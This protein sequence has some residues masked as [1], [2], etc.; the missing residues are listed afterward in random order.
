MHLLPDCSRM[1]ILALVPDSAS[2]PHSSLACMMDTVLAR[3]GT[4][5][6]IHATHPDPDGT[7]RLDFK[8]VIHSL[9]S[10]VTTGE[11]LLL[12]GTAYGFV[13]LTEALQQPQRMFK[14]PAGSRIMETGGYK[15]QSR[16]L[17]RDQL[18]QLLSHSLDIPDPMMVSEYGM[19]ELSSQAYDRRVG[20]SSP[21]V[22]HFPP[23]CAC[24]VVSPE[25]GD[26]VADGATG[27][28]QVF[29]LANVASVLAIQTE[30][31]AI[32][33]GHG[34][35][36]LGRVPGAESRGCSLRHA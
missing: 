1:N 19:T 30:D 31:L 2:A 21:R 34:F 23:W 32:R 18:H 13:H 10:S 17:P 36:H 5:H 15:G 33:R 4:G 8:R 3:H 11:P 28:L 26:P 25:T 22:F 16:S 9:E 20:D 27:V 7:W 14:L 29:D 12:A 24:R 35:E 6:S